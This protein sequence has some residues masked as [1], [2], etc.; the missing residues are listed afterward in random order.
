[1]ITKNLLLAT[2][3]G[4]GSGETPIFPIIVFKVK[5]GVNFNEGD[6]NY[7]LYRLSLETTSKRLFPNYVFLDA[8]FNLKYYDGTP[9]SEIAT[10]G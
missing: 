10:M 2:Q 3:G 7:D 4:L 1:M 8:P 6:P 5:N 9:Q